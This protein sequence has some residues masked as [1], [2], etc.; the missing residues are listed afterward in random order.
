MARIWILLIVIAALAAGYMIY[1]GKIKPYQNIHNRADTTP[2]PEPPS[3][4]P[5]PKL[6]PVP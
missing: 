4:I 5:P 2:V 1:T 6:D 3:S